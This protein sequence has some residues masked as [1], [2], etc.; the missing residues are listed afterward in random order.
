[1]WGPALKSYTS[2]IW[3]KNTFTYIYI[4]V[5]V[6]VCL[7][8][9]FCTYTHIHTCIYLYMYTCTYIHL[10]ITYVYINEYCRYVHIYTFIYF[11]NCIRSL[12]VDLL[13]LSAL[14]G[15]A[16]SVHREFVHVCMLYAYLYMVVPQS[17]V[18]FTLFLYWL[19]V[20]DYQGV[21]SSES[22]LRRVYISFTQSAYNLHQVDW[23]H[24]TH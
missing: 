6:Y 12:F 24:A 5:Y 8:V 10:R 17:T 18:S 19:C 11:Y 4:Y 9:S 21:C 1:M 14:A 7:R 20:V 22:Y 13:L 3:Y 2:S 16:M 23:Q 15:C